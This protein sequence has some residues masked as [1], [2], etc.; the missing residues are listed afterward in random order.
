[1]L[2]VE[3]FCDSYV[4]FEWV[5]VFGCEV[6]FCLENFVCKDSR[7]YGGVESC[8]GFFEEW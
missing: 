7:G 3:K 4:D 1:M 6:V 5:G 2:W 8:G